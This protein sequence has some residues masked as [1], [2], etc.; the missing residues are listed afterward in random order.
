M[1]DEIDKIAT[2]NEIIKLLVDGDRKIFEALFH[3]YYSQLCD[4]ALT[5]LED[6]NAAEDAVQDVFVYLWNYRKSI[7]G[8]ASLKSYLYSSV[9]HRALN[10]LKHQAIIRK[11]SPLLV[12]FWWN[13]AK[14]DYS[15]QELEQLEQVKQA[16]ELLPSQCRIVFM[17]SC[18]EGKKYKEIADELNI[19]V[20]T[21]KSHILKAYHDIRASVNHPIS[22][23]VL[24]FAMYKYAGIKK[25]Y[26]CSDF[27]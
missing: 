4:Y 13:L 8:V 9:K 14:E 19:S 6:A 18:L 2:D 11:H 23:Q 26:H 24:F 5:Y 10:I 21:V 15:E 7:K 17:M 3:K 27:F 20:N 1:H 16:F 22:S 12:E 25:K